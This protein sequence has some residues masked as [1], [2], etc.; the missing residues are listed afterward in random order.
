MQSE[1]Q[2]VSIVLPTYN[3]SQY[4]SEAIESCLLQTYPDWELIIVDDGS[5]DDTIRRVLSYT[6]VDARIALIRHSKNRTL[7]AALNTGFGHAKGEYLT[8]TSDDNIFE[9]DA[10]EILVR[11]LDENRQVDFVYCDMKRID[12]DGRVTDVW[13]AEDA[14]SLVERNVIGG[15]FLFR[16]E[17][18]QVVGQFATDMFLIEDYDYWLRVNRRFNM[19][20]L[21]GV[22][23]Y[24]YRRHSN[25]LTRRREWE[26]I[27]NIA[28]AQHRHLL[29]NR[30]GR[31]ALAKA[32]WTATWGMRGD[33]DYKRACVYAFHCL[34][35][36]PGCFLHWR[37]AIGTT[38]KW[39]YYRF[40]N[41]QGSRA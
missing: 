23:P 24:R 11:Y 25:S 22:S 38:F 15:C 12:E 16:R 20:H 14:A 10:L 4:I 39:L 7:P 34:F 19:T 32:Y 5:T 8:W 1:S 9:P 35:L 27:I 29:P 41:L 26:V 30:K 2:L 18:Y 3:G 37:A 33:G 40:T 13:K 36:Q 21:Q 17:I 28:R 31:Y 6:E